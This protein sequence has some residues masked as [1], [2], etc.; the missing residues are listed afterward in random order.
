MDHTRHSLLSIGSFA[1]AT[2]LSLKALRLYDQLGILKPAYI[3]PDSNYRYYHLDQLRSATL[4][5]LMRQIDMPLATIRSVLAASPDNAEALITEYQ[6][7]VEARVE[8]V[9]RSVHDL[10]AY[11][12]EEEPAMAWDVQVRNVGPQHVVSITRHVKIDQL[13]DHISGSIRTLNELAQAQGV[14]PDGLPF[15]IYHGPVNEND[16]GPMEMCLP[17][18]GAVTASGEVASKSL[19]A[20]RLAYV[21]IMGDD[22]E[23]P[24]ILKAY[25]VV[26]HWIARN[27]YQHDGPPW[28]IGT[29]SNSGRMQI[30]WPF[31]E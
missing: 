21:D 15:G 16:N 3:D 4:I 6:L 11:L 8:H 18:R 28:E 1:T 7:L 24:A 17:V 19:P 23:F 13:M 14:E 2:Q 25:D 12:H 20:A 29:G 9:R 31:H 22:C 26:Y 10:L 5:R 30:A 27:G